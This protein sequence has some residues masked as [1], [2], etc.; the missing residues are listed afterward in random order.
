MVLHTYILGLLSM[1]SASS[2]AI[3]IAIAPRSSILHFSKATMFNSCDFVTLC[4]LALSV[5]AA[6]FPP[7]PKGVTVIPSQRFPGVSISYKKASRALQFVD[8]YNP[9]W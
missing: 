8:H 3:A 7:E 9:D 4:S 2:P 5:S 6:S 1:F